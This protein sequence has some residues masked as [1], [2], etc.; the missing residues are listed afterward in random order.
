MASL[1]Q[2]GSTYYIQY[3]VSGK[4]KRASTGTESLQIAKEKLRQFESAQARGDELPL[5]SKT[6]IADVMTA[7]V[8]HIRAVKTAKSAQTDIYYLRDAFGPI[9]DALKITSRKVSAETKKRPPKPGQDRRRKAPVI[10]A[11][12]F[13]QIT[14]A[15]IAG[16][17]SGQV[18]S[19]GL[20]PK[21]ANRYREILTRLFNWAMT[22]HG[23]R[24]PR[25]K[26]P[27][28]AVER[29]KEHAPEISFLTLEEIDKQLD[30]VAGDAKMQTAV[31]TLI[32]A[33]L[34]REELLWLTDDDIDWNAGKHGL[35]RVRAK[36]V[37]GESWQP[38]TKKNRGVPISSRLRV[39]LDKL[40]LKKFSGPWLF[41]NSDG[42]RYDPDNFSSDLR[43]LNAAK[44]LDWTNLDYRHTFGS[45]LAMKGE[46]LYKIATLMGNSPEI[47]RR[48]YAAL[49]PESLVDSVEFGEAK[50]TSQLLTA[51]V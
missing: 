44:G 50:A 15:D 38:K 39:Y 13:E 1:I 10:E 5:P 12:C 30:A 48:H 49:M 21:T 26:N 46:S 11:N 23:I 37:N 22:Q 31:A 29:Y 34:R 9:C 7:Y 28:A 51:T 4:A 16:F 45:Q 24:T 3:M 6:P 18:K 32:F 35:I 36:T 19:R 14:T 43:T 27:A 25:E 47:C 2:R 40:K 41:P 8:A 20:A 42:G 33:G 17:I